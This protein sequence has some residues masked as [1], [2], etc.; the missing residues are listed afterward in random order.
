VN[1]ALQL[2]KQQEKLREQQEQE[3]REQAA[4]AA[5]GILLPDGPGA[6]SV[7]ATDEAKK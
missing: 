6:V 2:E 5:T 4:A 3:Q 7:A 1:D